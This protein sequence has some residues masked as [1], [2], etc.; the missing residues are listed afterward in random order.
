VSDAGSALEDDTRVNERGSR[1]VWSTV[2]PVAPGT[3]LRWHR[4]LVA[5]KRTY[6]D[7]R[8]RDDRQPAPIFERSSSWE[9]MMDDLQWKR[10]TCLHQAGSVNLGQGAEGEQVS[11][12]DASVSQQV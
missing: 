1:R 11:W 12:V 9:F 6:A 7:W 8:G 5:R 10:R 4:R 3:A 2:F